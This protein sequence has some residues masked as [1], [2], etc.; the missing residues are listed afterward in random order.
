M[1][2]RL[3]MLQ[4]ARLAPVLLGEGAACLV[5]KFAMSRLHPSGGF[6]GREKGIPD[7]YYTVFGLDILMALQLPLVPQ[8]SRFLESRETIK[9]NDFVHLCSRARC[10][11]CFPETAQQVASPLL[12]EIESYRSADGGYNQGGKAMPSGSAY[13]CFLAYGAYSDLGMRMPDADA[14]ISSLDSLRQGCGGWSNDT[15]IPVANVPATAAAITVQRNLGVPI[16]PTAAEFLLSCFQSRGGGF[17][18]FPG[19]PLPDLLTTAVALHAL[20]GMQVP[21]EAVREPCLDFID[22]LW[23]AEGGFHGSWEDDVLDLEYTYYGLLALG[24]LAI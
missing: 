11:S 18:P 22:S 10:L 14:V 4:C 19:A 6:V 16:S 3:E 20:D 17:G 13:A 5:E 24:H 9:T 12:A 23:T 21:L 15:Q 1:S 7:L 2:V 8:I